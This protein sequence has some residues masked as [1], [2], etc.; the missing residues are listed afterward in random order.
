MTLGTPWIQGVPGIFKKRQGLADAVS[1]LEQALTLA[2]VAVQNVPS[3][4]C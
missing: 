4:L 3:P 1:E 2:T